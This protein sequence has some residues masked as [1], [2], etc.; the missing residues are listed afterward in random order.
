[1]KLQEMRELARLKGI[2]IGRLKKKMDIV[3]AIQRDEGNDE[4]FM[5][6]RASACGQTGC[7]WL[8]DCTK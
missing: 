2:E 4:C 5:S 3:R 7:L 6:E 1:M 8:E